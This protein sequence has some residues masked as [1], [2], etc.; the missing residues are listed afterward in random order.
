MLRLLRRD[1]SPAALYHRLQQR[2]LQRTLIVHAGLGT[3]WLEELLRQ[4]GGAGHFRIDT[5]KPPGQPPTPVEWLVHEVLLPAAREAGLS[6]PLLVQ[7]GAQD[8]QVRHL[9]R[10]G[11]PVHPAQLGLILAELP[12]RHHLRLV[13]TGQGGFHVEP[14]LDPED[15]EIDY[16]F[17]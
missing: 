1:R 11:F 4:P 10:R 12:R 17:V 2:Y 16:D 7:I 3:A 8:L 5:R 14:G 13:A 9:N 6:L 15:N